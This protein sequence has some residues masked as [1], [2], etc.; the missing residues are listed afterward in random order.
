MEIRRARP[1]DVAGIAA[2]HVASWQEAYR[3]RRLAAGGAMKSDTTGGTAVT[4]LR[5][6]RALT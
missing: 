5:Y 2:V 3:G 4:E 6:L 1:D